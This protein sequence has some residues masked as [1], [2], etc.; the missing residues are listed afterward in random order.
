MLT[1]DVFCYIIITVKKSENVYGGKIQQMSEKIPHR[2]VK[3]FTNDGYIDLSVIDFGYEE[4]NPLHSYGPAIRDYYLFHYII[5]GKGTLHTYDNKS[6][7]RTYRLEGGKGFMIWPGFV[8]KYIADGDE[9]WVYAWIG[10]TGLKA[11]GFVAQSGLTVNQPV[12]SA[13]ST[14]EE[15]FVKAKLMDMIDNTGSTNIELMGYFYLFLGALIETSTARRKIPGENLQAFYVNEA[16]KYMEQNY[17]DKFTID[18]IAAFCNLNRSYLGKIFKSVLKISPQDF[19]IKYRVNRACELMK[20][21]DSNISEI[22]GMVGYPNLFTFSR[23]F[24][25]IIGQSPKEWRIKNKFK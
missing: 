25:K 8:N 23:A 12:Y 2:I 1:Q 21:T 9:P 3:Y 6:N 4:C 19:L 18:D 17:R 7:V 14:D 10:F 11:L 22:C 24:K 20:T 16:I 13:R 15:N 5:S